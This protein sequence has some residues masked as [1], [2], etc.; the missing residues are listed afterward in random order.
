MV[1]VPLFGS[2]FR[3]E[4]V[5]LIS[6]AVSPGSVSCVTRRHHGLGSKREKQTDATVVRTEE[7]Y[8]VQVEKVAR[9]SPGG[10]MTLIIMNVQSL[11]APDQSKGEEM[12]PLLLEG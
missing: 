9:Q 10:V 12:A 3:T 5:D 4:S 8:E 11:Q 2:K 7:R 1:H 6:A